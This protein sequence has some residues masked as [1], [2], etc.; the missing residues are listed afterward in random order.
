MLL[1]GLGK[2][3]SSGRLGSQSA[4]KILNVGRTLLNRNLSLK[5]DLSKFKLNSPPPGGVVGTSN[6]AFKPPEPDYF[7]GSYHW[8]YE[9]I[10]A[11][12]LIPLTSIPLYITLTGGV[13]PP[14]LDAA[15]G[16]V[17]LLHV[18]QG[19]TS[20]II[21]YIPKRKFGIWHDLARYLLFGGSG[22]GLYGIYD[23]E[24]SNNGIVDLLTK[25]LKEDESNLY[26]FGRN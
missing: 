6:D 24:T 17:L 20:C 3:F 22:L 5:P 1:L 16:V 11:A 26:I 12:S 14:L 4:P 2:S 21:D 7:H 25:I 13:V 10:T 19:L 15:L 9:R 18:N 23:L 8:Y